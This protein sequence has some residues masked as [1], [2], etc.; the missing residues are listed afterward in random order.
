ML[1]ATFSII[2]ALH[3]SRG[4]A[5][6]YPLRIASDDGRSSVLF[7]ELAVHVHLTVYRSDVILKGT[8]LHA[9]GFNYKTINPTIADR[10]HDTPSFSITCIKHAPQ[11]NPTHTA[12]A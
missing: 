3:K 12:M 11:P 1:N 7:L 10:A 9:H 6:E 4:R 8:Q 5:A 2:V